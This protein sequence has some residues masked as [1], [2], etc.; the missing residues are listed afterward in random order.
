MSELR[1][2]PITGRWIIFI[3]ERRHRRRHLPHQYQ[4]SPEEQVCPFCEGK[5]HLTPPEIFAFR[6][7]NSKPNTTGW[8]VRVVPDISPI[9]NVEKEFKS[10]GI[11]IYDTMDGLGAHE[12]VVESNIHNDNYDSMSI[13]QIKDIFRAYNQRITD[14]SKDVRLKYILINKNFRSGMGTHM[15]FHHP[16]SHLVAYPFIPH[17]PETEC[18][19][20]KVFWNYHNRCIY[21][22][23]I[24]QEL[25]EPNERVIYSNEEFVL[26]APFSSR[27]PYEMW[28]IPVKHSYIFSG[29][30]SQFESLAVTFKEFINRMNAV[31]SNPPYN[32]II[33]S[34]PLSEEFREYYHWHIEIRP[35]ISQVIGFEWGTGTYTN[36]VLPELAAKEMREVDVKSIDVY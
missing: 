15:P 25:N 35:R 11:G 18:E 2:D 1:K 19:G 5:E 9:L 10:K 34:S 13:D 27:Y 29:N 17:I 8:N 22:D 32:F 33:H 36:A 3:E 21:C 4:E 7:N 20:A 23:I 16:H 31:L 26:I 24:A 28:I 12:I 30:D 14:L 6:R